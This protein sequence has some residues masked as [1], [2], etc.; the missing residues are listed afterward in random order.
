MEKDTHIDGLAGAEARSSVEP[1]IASELVD[2]D[3]SAIGSVMAWLQRHN[4]EGRLA[5]SPV[6]PGAKCLRTAE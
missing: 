1:V 3:S 5:S 6:R 2:F 4:K